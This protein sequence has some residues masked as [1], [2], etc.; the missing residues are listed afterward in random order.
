M[1]TAAVD[2]TAMLKAGKTFPSWAYSQWTVGLKK[3][4]PQLCVTAN[5]S[6]SVQKCEFINL[7]ALLRPSTV[8]ILLRSGQVQSP[9]QELAKLM[10]FHEGTPVVKPHLKKCTL[11]LIYWKDLS[12]PLLF[13]CSSLTGGYV[14]GGS[15]FSLA[16]T[17]E[18]H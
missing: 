5:M 14:G 8:C 2:C 3:K 17:I 9:L 18:F 1:T 7:T 6:A 13:S 10:L 16:N 11:H 12:P 15:F 4:S